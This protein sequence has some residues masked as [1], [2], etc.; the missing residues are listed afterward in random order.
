MT[1]SSLNQFL[2]VQKPGDAFG[3]SESSACANG[4]G[5][6]ASCDSALCFGEFGLTSS[7]VNALYP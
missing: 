3:H 5:N 1:I 7:Q 4:C 6:R 2:T